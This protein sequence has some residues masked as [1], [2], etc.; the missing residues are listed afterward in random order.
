[1]L[2]KF[3]GGLSILTN[4]DDQCEPISLLETVFE[5]FKNFIIRHSFLQVR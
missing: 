1:M 5:F 4:D 2:N 3:T